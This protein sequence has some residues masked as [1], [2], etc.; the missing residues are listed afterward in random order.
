MP[1]Q[2]TCDLHL[3]TFYSD[4]RA[5]PAEML[6]H[7]ADIGLTT[8][9]ITDHD[10]ADGAR[11]A[12]PIAA[13]LGLELIPAIEFTC[14][15][16]DCASPDEKDIDVL[17]Y[18]VDIDDPQFQRV[19]QAALDDLHQR[20]ADCCAGLTAAGYPVTLDEVFVENPR[21]AGALQLT[22]ALRRKGFAEDWAASFALFM[23]H[24]KRARPSHLTI[25]QAIAAIH[26][27]GGVAVLAHPATIRCDGQWLQAEQMAALVEMGLDGVEIYHF[28]LDAAA[29]AHFLALAEQFDLLVSGGSDDHGWRP[30][31]PRMGSEPVTLEMVQ[32]LR[33]RSSDDRGSQ[34]P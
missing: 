24:W 22:F 19:E 12:L 30:G 23:P 8:V 27:A 10:N 32:A 11:E 6:Q 26:A 2:S 1:P 14:R 9:A 13:Q 33:A 5:S 25:D 29:R 4:G 17:G 7:A 21:Y 18:F 31:F 15:W 34:L 28:R 20:I 3:H 16:D